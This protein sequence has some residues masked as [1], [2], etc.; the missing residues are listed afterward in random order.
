MILITSLYN[1]VGVEKKYIYQYIKNYTN[2]TR[3]AQ[4]KYYEGL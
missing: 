3:E 1:F 2:A 4:R